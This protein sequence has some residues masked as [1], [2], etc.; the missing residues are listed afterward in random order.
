VVPYSAALI[1]SADHDSAAAGAKK[2][3]TIAAEMLLV[4]KVA[5]TQSSS[6][7]AEPPD[8]VA[9]SA[10][11]LPVTGQPDIELRDP[12]VAVVHGQSVPFDGIEEGLTWPA[13]AKALGPRKA[14]DVVTLQVARTVP[15][16]DLLR[17]AWA[18]HSVDVHLQSLDA[19]GAMH[20]VELRARRDGAPEVLCLQ[21]LHGVR[22]A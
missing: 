3:E 16:Q 18:V 8:A 11:T 13:L 7:G 20:A 17:A 21:E 5:I 15:M 4:T 14:G 9:A 6:P 10:P 22:T 12:H 2:F 19:S 1:V